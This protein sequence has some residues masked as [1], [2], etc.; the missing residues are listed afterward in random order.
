MQDL[1]EV[2]PLWGYAPA[3]TSKSASVTGNLSWAGSPANLDII[4]SEEG[5]HLP[6][7]R[8]GFWT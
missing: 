6:L 2:L 8:V 1:A 4:K 7:C 3:V 5:F